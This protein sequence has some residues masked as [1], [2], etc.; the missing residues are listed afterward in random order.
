MGMAIDLGQSYNSCR[1]F[2]IWRHVAVADGVGVCFG[3]VDRV[4]SSFTAEVD[5]MTL[6]LVLK[7]FDFEGAIVL[8]AFDSR[9]KAINAA[10]EY[11][12]EYIQKYSKEAFE[13]DGDV[14][15]QIRELNTMETGIEI[16]EF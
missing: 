13:C 9:E 1:Y 10:K 5:K 12:K 16:K 11:N 3:Y 2:N 7:T 14:V 8:G 15:I 6:F 4:F